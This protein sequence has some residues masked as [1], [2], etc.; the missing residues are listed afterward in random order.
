MEIC[1]AGITTKICPSNRGIMTELSLSVKCSNEDKFIVK[2]DASGTVASLKAAI[3]SHLETSSIPTPVQNQRLIFAGRVL[4][5]E[6]ALSTYK[7]QDGNTIH[8]VRSGLKAAPAPSSSA[9]GADAIA[10]SATSPVAQATTAPAPQQPALPTAPALSDNPFASLFAQSAASSPFGGSAAGSGAATNPFGFAPPPGAGG[11][12]PEFAN[13]PAFIQTMGTLLSNPGF[14]DLMAQTNP[15]F[16]AMMTPEIRAMMQSESFRRI[17]SDPNV[18]RQMM[19]MTPH[20]MGGGVNPFG[21]GPLGTGP[22]AGAN[23]PLAAAAASR[24]AAGAEGAPG[25]TPGAAAMN[26]TGAGGFDPALLSMLMGGGLGGLGGLS[27]AAAV[28]PPPANP[29]EAYQ[30]QLRQLQEMGFYDASENIR[31]LTATRGDVTAAV[32]YLFNNPPPG[33]GGR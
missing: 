26:P 3:A 13:D 24:S 6:E 5:D 4:K 1:S 23:N 20:M 32:E 8:L 33:F 16:A 29:E 17:M 9:S 11:L 14:I 28:P 7:I 25:A 30:V 15:Q 2:V 19:Q 18:V 21:P 27:R 12:P 10:A 22:T 31:A